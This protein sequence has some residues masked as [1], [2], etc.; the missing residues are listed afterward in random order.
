M[1]SNQR[2][3]VR[4]T[5]LFRFVVAFREHRAYPLRKG[6]ILELPNLL[7]ELSNTS[8]M[9]VDV[10]GQNAA[11]TAAARRKMGCKTICINPTDLHVSTYPDLKSS[12]CNPMVAGTDPKGP[13]FY[14]ECIAIAEAL[15][16]SEKGDAFFSK[17]GKDLVAALIGW[18]R[19]RDG[20]NANISTVVELLCEP[21]EFIDDER[22]ELELRPGA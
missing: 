5:C 22:S 16:W 15:N 11:I 10:T 20:E 19:L 8:V 17:S 21:D 12:G 7:L 9:S 2:R 18:V 1:E 6:D 4:Q 13:R 3:Q 14:E